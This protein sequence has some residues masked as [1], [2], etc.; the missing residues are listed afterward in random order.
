MTEPR[1]ARAPERVVLEGRFARL[2]PLDPDRHGRDLWREV[3]GH[4]RIW[5]YMAY[6]PFG[7]EAEFL[8]WLKT[9][10]KLGDPLHFAV[11]DRA[12]GRALGWATLMEIRPAHG[13]IEIGNILFSPA[14]QKTR[15]ATEAIFLLMTHAFE[16][17]GNRRFEWKCDDRNAPSKR[18]AGRFGFTFEGLFR[19]HMII[20][21]RNRDTAWFSILDREW[22]DVKRAFAAWLAPDNFDADGRQRAGL[23]AIRE[24]QP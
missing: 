20:K 8:A 14:L 11:L 6:G 1:P 23:A 19:Q 13:V 9:R 21:G 15:V 12:T 22:P 10:A 17:L 5:D 24:R 4:D 18:A 7:S 16:D 2:E 3:V